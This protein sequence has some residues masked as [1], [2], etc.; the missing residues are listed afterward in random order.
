[1]TP[2]DSP[3][4]EP[5][6]HGRLTRLRPAERDDVPLLV[7][8][9]NDLATVRFLSARAPMSLAAEERWFEDMTADQ[10][11]GRWH[12]LICRLDDDRPIGTI[13]L[14]EID[15]TNGSAGIGITIGDPADTGRGFGSDALETLLDFGFG[16]LRLDRLWLDAYAF[17]TRAIA[18]YERVGFVHEGVARHGAYRDG[19]FVDVVAMAILRDEWA[20]RRATEPFP[21]AWPPA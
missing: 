11:R 4:P 21:G 9:F 3:R 8:W 12:F 2:A 20:A 5:V 18:M 10:G 14:F 15:L 1:V 6:L 19:E 16:R 13:G 7:R 17:N